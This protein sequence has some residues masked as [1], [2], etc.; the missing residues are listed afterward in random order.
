MKAAGFNR[1]GN[2]GYNQYGQNGWNGEN[3]GW[4]G[5]NNSSNNENGNGWNNNR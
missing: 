5:Q 1:N 2:F 4:N 3:N